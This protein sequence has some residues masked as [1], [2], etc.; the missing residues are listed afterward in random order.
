VF[1][2]SSSHWSS[3]F[4]TVAEITRIID[5]IGRFRLPFKRH[6]RP[7]LGYVHGSFILINGGVENDITWDTD[8]LAEDF[9]FGLRVDFSR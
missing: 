6:K 3:A 4:L 9:W 7:M 1:Y 8:C 2:N 5:D